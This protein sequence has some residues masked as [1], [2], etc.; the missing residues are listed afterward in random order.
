MNRMRPFFYLGGSVKLVVL[1]LL[2]TSCT[3]TINIEEDQKLE[4]DPPKNEW[5]TQTS[6]T[7]VFEQNITNQIDKLKKSNWTVSEPYYVNGFR[8]FKLTRQ[9]NPLLRTYR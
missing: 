9:Y 8:K 7:F 5:I 3:I 4:A 6:E 2:M 1:S